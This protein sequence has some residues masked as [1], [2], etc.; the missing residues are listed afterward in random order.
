MAFIES[1]IILRNSAAH[2]RDEGNHVDAE[3]LST[4]SLSEIETEEADRYDRTEEN[5]IVRRHKE[6]EPSHQCPTIHNSYNETR[7]EEEEATGSHLSSD[8]ET[9]H[10]ALE[11]SIAFLDDDLLLSCIDE[12]HLQHYT[13]SIFHKHG[14]SNY[15]DDSSMGGFLESLNH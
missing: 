1:S 15:D 11:K 6:D 8:N 3:E 12:N 14:E 4:I 7:N 9:L 5:P 2:L 13:N 10:Q